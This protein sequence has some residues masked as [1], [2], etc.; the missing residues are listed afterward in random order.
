[1]RLCYYRHE[2]GNFG[3]DLNPWLWGKLMPEVLDDDD[4]TMFIGM[5]TLLGDWF[6]GGL[7]LHARRVVLG[8]GAGKERMPPTIDDRWTIYGVRGPLTAAWMGLDPSLALTDPAAAV[9]DLVTERPERRTGVGF[10]PHYR[11]TYHWNWRDICSELGLIYIDPS[12]PP[13]ATVARI[14]GLERLISEAMHGAIVADALRTPWLAVSITPE[15]RGKWE[16]WGASVRH[17]V[18]F[19]DLPNLRNCARGLSVADRRKLRINHGLY[20]FGA[21]KKRLFL[22]REPSSSRWDIDTARTRLT[23]LAHTTEPFLSR[24]A[25]LDEALARFYEAVERLRRDFA[26]GR[27]AQPHRSPLIAR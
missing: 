8:S 5:G 4:A 22:P 11:S 27:F 20:E 18:H 12:Y 3:D 17:I 19:F 26:A 14:A 7:P 16:D 10:M 25:A 15:Y 1:M 23:E 2:H 9:R 13:E 24:D 6:D 21:A